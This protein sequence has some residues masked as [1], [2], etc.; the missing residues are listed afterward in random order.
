MIDLTTLINALIAL[1][2]AVITAFV[3]PWIKSKTTAQQRELMESVVKSLVYA[4]E[5]IF[6][7][8]SGE[9]KLQYVIDRLRAMGYTVDLSLIEATVKE[10]FGHWGSDGTEDEVAEAAPG[11]EDE[12]P[13][14]ADE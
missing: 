3:I 5:Q 1:M 13:P 14:G 7:A 8:G 11:V 9:E 2:A 4:A 12:R 6:G 10:H